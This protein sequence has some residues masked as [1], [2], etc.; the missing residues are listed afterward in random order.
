M[1]TYPMIKKE[2]ENYVI[3]C[4]YF[5]GTMGVC[6]MT[7]TKDGKRVIQYADQFKTLDFDAEVEKLKEFYKG[8][9]II[10][11]VR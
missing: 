9:S 8:C 10:K 4:D 5:E 7:A 3:G 2:G 11:E 6:I 1:S